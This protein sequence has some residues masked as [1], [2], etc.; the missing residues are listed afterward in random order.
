MR[1]FAGRSCR[2]LSSSFGPLSTIVSMTFCRSSAVDHL[3]ILNSTMPAEPGPMLLML[4]AKHRKENGVARA[5]GFA[6]GGGCFDCA[7]PARPSV[8][9]AIPVITSLNRDCDVMTVWTFEERVAKATYLDHGLAYGRT[10][11]ATMQN[12]H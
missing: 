8:A 11:P 12:R 7:V 1:P 10:R 3:A 6:L 5:F 4:T 9:T 2:R